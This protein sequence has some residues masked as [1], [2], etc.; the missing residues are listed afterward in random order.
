MAHAE[1]LLISS[2]ELPGL[3]DDMVVAGNTYL[4]LYFYCTGQIEKAKQ[5]LTEALRSV[6]LLPHEL[7]I[8]GSVQVIIG[9]GK[10][11]SINFEPSDNDLCSVCH[12]YSLSR[13]ARIVSVLFILNRFTWG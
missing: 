7:L 1:K 9:I 13:G 3:F 12:V 2:V 5:V 10:V 6:I 11:C 4:G 8:Y